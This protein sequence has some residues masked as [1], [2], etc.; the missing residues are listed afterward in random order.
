MKKIF[1]LLSVIGMAVAVHA[2]SKSEK[3][4]DAAVNELNTALVNADKSGLDRITAPELSYGHSSGKIENKDQFI[5]GAMT[6][7]VDFLT[8]D[9]TDKSIKI[10]GDDAIAR[11]IFSAKIKNK[12]VPGELKIGNLLVWQKQKGKWKLIA[13]QAYKL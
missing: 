9:L 1:I 2:Q 13:R 5:E 8:I 4:V 10:V 3:E 12:G 7:P 6:G 11:H